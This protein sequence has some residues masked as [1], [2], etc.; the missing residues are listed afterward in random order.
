MSRDLAA[1]NQ[2]LRQEID[3]LTMV[4]QHQ[5]Q[6]SAEFLRA[7]LDKTNSMQNELSNLQAQSANMWKEYQQLMR[8]VAAKQHGGHLGHGSISRNNS[9]RFERLGSR[10]DLMSSSNGTHSGVSSLSSSTSSLHINDH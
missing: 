4:L 2:Y 8:T 9:V 7:D 5:K 10:V 3:K 1:E 6:R